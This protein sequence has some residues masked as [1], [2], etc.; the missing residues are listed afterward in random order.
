MSLS[1]GNGMQISAGRQAGKQNRQQKE[2]VANR[3]IGVGN[4]R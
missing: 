3:D 1:C 2:E 4:G